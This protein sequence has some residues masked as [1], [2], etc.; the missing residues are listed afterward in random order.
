MDNANILR[1]RLA[2]FNARTGPR[3]GD[4]LA[5]APPDPRCPTYTRFTHD[6]GD[7]IQTGGQDGSYYF[8]STGHLSYSGGLDPGIPVAAD[9]AD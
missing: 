8:S 3:V 6:W 7:H 9:W 5:L 2:A 4:W 1:S